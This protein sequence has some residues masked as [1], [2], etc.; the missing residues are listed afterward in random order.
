MSLSSHAPSRALLTLWL[1]LGLAVLIG[2]AVSLLAAAAPSPTTPRAGEVVVD[3]PTTFWGALLLSPLLV[4]FAGIL[5]RWARAPRA[6]TGRTIL[7]GFAIL[8]L[9]GVSLLLL[10]AIAHPTAGTVGFVTNGSTGGSTNTSGGSP[11]PGGSGGTAGGGTVPGTYVYTVGTWMM[12]ALVLAISACV[13]LL[14]VPGVLSRLAGRGPPAARPAPVDRR[15]VTEAFAEASTAMARGEDFR[16]TIV[17]LYV[18]LLGGLAPKAGNFDC[19]T[20][21]EIRLRVLEHLGVQADPARDL[22]RLFE[23]ARYSSHTMGEVEADRF[24]AAVATIEQDL[25]RGPA[26]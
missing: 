1:L 13:G 3:L 23:V 17:R 12:L 24:R 8:L 16:E 20:P 6:T 26:R 18:R 21:E 10:L 22:T 25:Y 2:V 14:A 9:V 15:Q 11:P 4:G 5:F 7:L 19:L